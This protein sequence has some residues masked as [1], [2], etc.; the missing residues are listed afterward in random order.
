MDDFVKSIRKLVKSFNKP[1]E[2]TSGG[3]LRVLLT[4]SSWSRRFSP[5]P[6]SLAV[7]DVPEYIDSSLDGFER[8]S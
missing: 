8:F 4:A 2:E 6:R 1:D 7:L 3:V 5:P